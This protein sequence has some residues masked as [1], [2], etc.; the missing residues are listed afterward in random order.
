MPT[1]TVDTIA[2]S[3]E[4]RGHGQGGTAGGAANASASSSPV[5]V[6]LDYARTRRRRAAP[7]RRRAAVTARRRSA[8]ALST[9]SPPSCPRLSLISLKRSR[10]MKCTAKRPPLRRQCG[11]GLVQSFNQAGAVRQACQRIVMGQ[12][13]DATVSALLLLGAAVQ[14]DRRN[15]EGQSP[16]TGKAIPQRSGT[17]CGP[18]HVPASDRHRPRRRRSVAD[19]RGRGQK[20]GRRTMASRGNCL[21]SPRRPVGRS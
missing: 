1:L 3:L 13:A 11:E 7:P 2:L 17:R 5:D 21:P 10:S 6:G 20:P 15:P 12:K 4:L 9:K 16:T 19:R 14:R 18:D 8:T